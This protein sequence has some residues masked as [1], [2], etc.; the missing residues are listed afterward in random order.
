MQENLFGAAMH[1]YYES[2]ILQEM[3]LFQANGCNQSARI[4]RRGLKGSGFP[5]MLILYLIFW[6]PQFKGLIGT[7]GSCIKERWHL[8][9]FA[10][11]TLTFLKPFVQ[12]KVGSDSQSS[13][14]GGKQRNL[15][16]QNRLDL[17]LF[18]EKKFENSN[19]GKGLFCRAQ[20]QTIERTD[21]AA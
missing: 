15:C 12:K 21:Q 6:R 2:F 19:F 18:G 8:V 9:T 7:L 14:E 13:N 3:P 11:Y 10:V 5:Q 16:H 1:L 17:K 4:F 20:Q